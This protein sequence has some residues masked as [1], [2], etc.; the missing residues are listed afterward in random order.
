MA[1]LNDGEL[2]ISDWLVS[3]HFYIFISVHQDIF[4]PRQTITTWQE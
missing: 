4:K 2:K 1:V 3:V